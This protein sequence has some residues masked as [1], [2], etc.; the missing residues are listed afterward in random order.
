MARS[1]V[2]A[3]EHEVANLGPQLRVDR[4]S[5]QA[6]EL[7]LDVKRWLSTPLSPGVAGPE[8]L[9]DLG[10]VF[11]GRRLG[12]G[13]RGNVRVAIHH[14]A[15]LTELLPSLAARNQRHHRADDPESADDPQDGGE[16]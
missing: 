9:A 8:Q 3:G 15:A 5:R 14:Q 2:A 11:D 7:Q 12:S 10:V 13:P 1:T 6:L 16:G 4:S